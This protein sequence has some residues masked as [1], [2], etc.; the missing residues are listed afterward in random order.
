[1]AS[2]RIPVTVGA[3]LLMMALAPALVAPAAVTTALAA[4]QAADPAS[5]APLK[6]APPQRRAKKFTKLTRKY[7]RTA[8][9]SMAQQRAAPA[10]RAEEAGTVM[11]GRHS[12]DLIAQLPWWRAGETQ[13]E[14]RHEKETA[15]PVLS[16][17]EAWLGAPIADSEAAADYAQGAAADDFN[18]SNL[19][20]ESIVV[21]DANEINE[22]DLAAAETP[23]PSDKTWFHALLAVLGGAFA[24]A[25]AA[26]F[27]LV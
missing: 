22:I 19:A 26:R 25:S 6:L 9:T 2:F 12:V 23:A 27:L 5:A 24:A 18:D 15:S 8:R 11:R 1:M 10:A 17:S 13:I 3:A 7:S 21:A 20:N 16:A 4:P 14:A